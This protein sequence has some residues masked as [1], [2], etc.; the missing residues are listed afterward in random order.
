M[1]ITKWIITL[2]PVAICGVIGMIADVKFDYKNKT[3]YFAL[4]LVGTNLSW[5]IAFMTFIN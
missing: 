5:V 1:I 4:G 2:L 3:F